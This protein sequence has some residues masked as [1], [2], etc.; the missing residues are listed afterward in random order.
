[1][2]PEPHGPLEAPPGGMPGTP[3]GTPPEPLHGASGAAQALARMA[4][5]ADAPEAALRRFVAQARWVDAGPGHIVMDFEDRTTDVLFIVQGEVR[6]LMRTADGERTQILGDFAAG[7]MLG[8]MAAIDNAPRSAQVV[9]LVRTRLCI[10]P[11][12]TF[13]ELVEAAPPVGL[14]LLQLLTARIRGGNQRLMERT[15]LPTRQRLACELLR[16]ARVRADG[17]AAVSPPPTHEELAE[18]IGAR[19]ETVSRELSVLARAGLVQRTRAAFVLDD[20]AALRAL[21]EAG[22]AGGAADREPA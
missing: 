22:R 1:M 5:L 2:T 7:Q 6:V 15:A 20:V 11:A 4:F 21:A 19:R 13:L 10:V 16:L 8:E 9:A 3:P 17:T 14:R 18:R 12:R